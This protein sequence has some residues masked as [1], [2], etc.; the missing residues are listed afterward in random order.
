MFVVHTSNCHGQNC[1]RR[2]IFRLGID[3]LIANILVTYIFT[4]LL[5]YILKTRSRERRSFFCIGDNPCCIRSDGQHSKKKVGLG[6]EQAVVYPQACIK[7]R[8][9]QRRALIPIVALCTAHQ[10]S[11][12]IDLLLDTRECKKPIKRWDS[13]LDLFYVD[14]AHVL[15]KF[16]IPKRT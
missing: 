8:S 2:A 14:I 6:H 10:N 3:T 13:E 16:K 4:E 7:Q 11:Q 12:S 9:A 15:Q 1:T 5:I